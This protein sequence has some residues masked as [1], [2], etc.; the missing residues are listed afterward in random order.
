[1]TISIRMMPA[2][3]FVACTNSSPTAKIDT[4]A[5]T[6]SSLATVTD[7]SVGSPDP[8]SDGAK[9]D[10]VRGTPV[11][12]CPSE[13]V[14]IAGYKENGEYILVPFCIDRYEASIKHKE[15]KERFSPY[16]S[17][18]PGHARKVRDTWESKRFET[19]DESA[20]VIELPKLP[21]WQLGEGVLQK[22]V[23]VPES[24]VIP[25]GYLSGKVAKQVCLNAGKRLCTPREWVRACRGSRDKKYP[26]GENGD[27]YAKDQCNVF[28]NT[29]PAQVL[30]N[31]VTSGHLDPRLNEVRDTVGEPLLRHTG[32]TKTCASKWGTDPERDWVYDMVGNLDEWVENPTGQFLGGF[33]SR[34][35]KKGCDASVT[36]HPTDY[37]DYSLGVRCCKNIEKN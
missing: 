2:V 31:D 36:T 28:R 30:H 7:A 20:R 18:D 26:Y 24:G 34:A 23:A 33:F 11:S 6:A 22:A 13:M 19:G 4:D 14:Y 15:S 5:E 12:R 29:H 17:P 16:Y 35:T 37:W 25:N 27:D 10:Q 9:L 3:F 8:I 1:M 21:D 32:E